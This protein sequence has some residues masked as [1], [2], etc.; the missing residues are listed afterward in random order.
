[1][2]YRLKKAPLSPV[3]YPY[4]VV[5]DNIEGSADIVT[6]RD[7]RTIKEK[8]KKKVKRGT[9]LEI[10]FSPVRKMDA[11]SVGKWFK[12]VGEVRS[13][14]HSSKCQLIISSGATS[15]QELVS[16]PS[17]DAILRNCEIDPDRHWDELNNWLKARLARRV[18]I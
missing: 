11:A 8:L 5:S 3:K 2:I 4:L 1:M 10:I 18:S 9:G 6:V 16:G 7:F 12:G 15:L 13:F 17:L 14:C